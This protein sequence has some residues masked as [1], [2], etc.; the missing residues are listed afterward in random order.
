MPLA[1]STAFDLRQSPHQA[2]PYITIRSAIAAS[3][4][5]LRRRFGRVRCARSG[6]DDERIDVHVDEWLAIAGERAPRTPVLESWDRARRERLDPE[7]TL[8]PTSFTAEEVRDYRAR[9]PLNAAMPVLRD[10]L[11]KE[12]DEDSGVVVAVGDA[13]G[14]LLWVEGDPALVRRAEAMRFVPGADWSEHRV[15]T[16]AP[17]TALAL[18]HGIQIRGQEHFALPVRDWSCTAVPVHD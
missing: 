7:R 12:A 15:G 17:G 13:A 10:L 8:A 4:G 2:A 16:S 11:V 1:S 5:A 18:D 9:H 3:V 6:L 14:R